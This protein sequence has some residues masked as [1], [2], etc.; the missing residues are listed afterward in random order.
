MIIPPTLFCNEGIPLTCTIDKHLHVQVHYTVMYNSS[1][2][3]WISIYMYK[4]KTCTYTTPSHVQQI[5]IY[6]YMYKII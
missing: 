5:S 6:K 2:V 1:F 4:Y 3:Q